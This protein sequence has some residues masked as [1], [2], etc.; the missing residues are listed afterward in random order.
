MDTI[1]QRESPLLENAT[2][3][4]VEMADSLSVVESISGKQGWLL[5][6]IKRP[7]D[8]NNRPFGGLQ[9]TKL[10]EERLQGRVASIYETLLAPFHAA[11]P[12]SS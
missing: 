6:A 8:Q 4:S 12:G 9:S 1:C 2:Q 10:A 3:V 7:L 11:P 5:E